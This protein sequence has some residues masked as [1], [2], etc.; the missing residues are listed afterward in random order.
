MRE[1]YRLNKFTLLD[2][3]KQE[4][5]HI[6]ILFS[7]SNNAYKDHSKINFSFLSADMPVLLN[8]LKNKIVKYQ[9]NSQSS[10]S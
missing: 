2:V 6:R 1:N 5:Q 9:N 3:I 10:A 7:L 4:D 8:K